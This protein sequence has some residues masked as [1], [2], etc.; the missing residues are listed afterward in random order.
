MNFEKLRDY[1][2][3]KKGVSEGF[4]FDETT[5]VFKVGSKMFALTGTDHDPPRVNLKNT[6][7]KILD[8]KDRYDAVLPGYYMNKLHW[9]TVVFDGSIPDDELEKMIDESY[10]IVYAKLTKKEKAMIDF[11]TVR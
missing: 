7:S 11:K 8:Y 6:P 10:D 9:N 4:P 3:S 2:L 5:L 1:C